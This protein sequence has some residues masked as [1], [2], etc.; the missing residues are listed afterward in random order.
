MEHIKTLEIF[1]IDTNSGFCGDR[2]TLTQQSGSGTGQAMTYNKGYIR[3]S[4][5]S[6]SL[7]CENERDYYTATSSLK[8]NKSLG[9]TVGL[10]TIDEVLLGGLSGGIFDGSYNY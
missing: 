3:V 5:S 6:P 7:I 9:Y 8:G 10:I 4:T 2:S 1:I